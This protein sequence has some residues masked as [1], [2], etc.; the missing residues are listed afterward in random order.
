MDLQLLVRIN[1]GRKAVFAMVKSVT[2][3]LL[4]AQHANRPT[5]LVD[6]T[7]VAEAELEVGH[8]IVAPCGPTTEE[9][10]LDVTVAE[11]L[12]DKMVDLVFLEVM[13][14]EKV[15]SKARQGEYALQV[16]GHSSNRVDTIFGPDGTPLTATAADL[17]ISVCM[18]H[19][20]AAIITALP[21][22]GNNNNNNDPKQLADHFTSVKSREELKQVQAVQAFWNPATLASV[23]PGINEPARMTAAS[24]SITA[25]VARLKLVVNSAFNTG[26]SPTLVLPDTDLKSILLGTSV[27]L[28][29]FAKPGTKKATP[30]VDGVRALS[31][32]M[33]RVMALVYDPTIVGLYTAMSSAFCDNLHTQPDDGS[34]IAIAI[35]KTFGLLSSYHAGVAPELSPH[36]AMNRAW[37]IDPNGTEMMKLNRDI[38]QKSIEAAHELARSAQQ[39]HMV[40]PRGRGGGAA[41]KAGAGGPRGNGAGADRGADLSGD[42]RRPR[43]DFQ[44]WLQGIPQAAQ[45]MVPRLCAFPG[46]VCKKDGCSL[47]HDIGKV[48]EDA[49]PA[50]DSWLSKRPPLVGFRPE[51]K[52]P[53]VKN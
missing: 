34:P 2:Q 14:A 12:G 50:V 28:A 23:F 48:P 45:A 35:E 16:V 6:A 26:L 18:E 13:D 10:A 9:G 44:V 29:A 42:K 15:A 5:S 32:T 46:G 47:E 21:P 53:K 4:A 49:R 36:D 51:R 7:I 37:T 52:K 40:N 8:V 19:S 41:G 39:L 11:Y 27:P 33:A 24:V 3:P 1:A 20:L 38:M 31:H 17:A 25:G 30:S 43:N 22:Q